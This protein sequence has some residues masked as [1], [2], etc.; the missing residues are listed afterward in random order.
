VD[1]GNGLVEA[2]FPKAR[3]VAIAASAVTEQ[4]DFLHARIGG[5]AEFQDPSVRAVHG[6]FGR[7]GGSADHDG[8]TIA[9]QLVESIGG[10]QSGSLAVETVIVDRYGLF[11]PDLS[12]ILEIA[13]KF[14]FLRGSESD[15]RR[16]RIV[17]GDRR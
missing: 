16:P 17:S 4:Q 6:E 14:L 12:W 8:S 11:L 9:N 3:P 13:D 5:P 15:G 10:D 7:A 2:V 1:S